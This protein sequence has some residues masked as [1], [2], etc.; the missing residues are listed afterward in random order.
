[1]WPNGE[2]KWGSAPAPCGHVTR[3]RKNEFES[4]R[5]E[6]SSSTSREE[7][8]FMAGS[9]HRREA[10]D[11]HTVAAARRSPKAPEAGSGSSGFAQLLSA[12][13]IDVAAKLSA[14]Q[15]S[16][17]KSA[18]Q[19][20]GDEAPETRDAKDDAAASDGD[21]RDVKDREADDSKLD[22][23]GY[24][25][26]STVGSES[27]SGLPEL[28]ADVVDASPDDTGMQA[29][30]ADDGSRASVANA[31]FV[32]LAKNAPTDI[33]VGAGFRTQTDGA[34]ETDIPTSNAIPE[35]DGSEDIMDGDVATESLP[36]S[37]AAES[38]SAKPSDTAI[39][40][41]DADPAMEA[42]EQV[43]DPAA[44]SETSAKPE[45]S[46]E[47]NSDI[48]LEADQQA[49]SIELTE[50]LLGLDGGDAMDPAADGPDLAA[51]ATQVARAASA[52]ATAATAGTVSAV[53]GGESA[54]QGGSAGQQGPQGG[55]QAGVDAAASRN[56]ARAMASGQ[57][58][59]FSKLMQD[60]QVEVVRQIAKHIGLRSAAS[61]DQRITMLLKP[62]SL[63]AVRLSMQF[64]EDGSLSLDARV[65]ES[66]TRRLI[67]SGVE[68]LRL[69]LKNEGVTLNRLTVTEQVSVSQG[70]TGNPGLG[71]AGNGSQAQ[72]GSGRGRARNGAS[73]NSLGAPATAGARE[74]NSERAG[75]SS[76]RL[77]DVDL[78]A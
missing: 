3:P 67:A 31:A 1:M 13:E 42:A 48:N 50:Q 64:E 34:P 69:S 2:G 12:V 39:E 59:Q 37:D 24:S 6:E 40:V 56:A 8:W 65:E 32:E 58:P 44:E 43:L 49:E 72:S 77:G 54:G 47:S 60:R 25:A 5:Q 62:E 14:D 68:E 16:V 29:V 53:S 51:P 30:T 46:S 35:S 70:G 21:Q 45:S 63:G 76:L 74:T 75:G 28:E 19:L 61:A 55:N 36:E 23:T 4:A 7:V 10:E 9:I 26:E 18:T 73:A 20:A 33:P 17:S 38:A 11:L 78:T 52:G 22:S 66:A 57:K 15:K 27:E 71:D 41:S